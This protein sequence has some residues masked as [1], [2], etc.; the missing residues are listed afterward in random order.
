MGNPGVTVTNPDHYVTWLWCSTNQSSTGS[1]QNRNVLPAT[2]GT[3]SCRPISCCADFAER[4]TEAR[5]RAWPGRL[6][7][8]SRSPAH[9]R[10]HRSLKLT[11]IQPLP[12]RGHW[13]SDK[14]LDS[15]R[16]SNDDGNTRCSL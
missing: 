8:T 16:G 4:W 1:N 14:T 10:T 13:A 9:A 11:P 3:T 12:G 6:R 5:V 15:S 7:T 2:E